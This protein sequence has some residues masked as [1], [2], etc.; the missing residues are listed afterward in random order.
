[1]RAQGCA[2]VTLVEPNPPRRTYLQD[3]CGEMVVE[4]WDGETPL[5]IDAVGYEVTRALASR[6]AL[7][8]GVIAHVGL[9]Q[10]TGG[11]DIRRM[12]LQEITFIGTYCYTPQDF[13]ETCAAIFDGRLG[14]LDWTEDRPLSDGQGAFDEIRAGSLAPPKVILKPWP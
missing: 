1:L 13:Q 7:P 4:S 3:Q 12:T 10:A 11:L 9:G 5:V 14:A 8:G 6:V 2:K